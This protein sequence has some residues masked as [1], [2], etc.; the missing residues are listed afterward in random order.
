MKYLS[1]DSSGRWKLRL[2]IPEALRKSIGKREFKH[3][4]GH[5]SQSEA[6]RRAHPILNDWHRQLDAAKQATNTTSHSAAPATSASDRQRLHKDKY[7]YAADTAEQPRA[8]QVHQ[9]DLD[10]Y[11]EA[12]RV[13]L[14][15]HKGLNATLAFVDDDPKIQQ[16]ALESTLLEGELY[17]HLLIPEKH[18]EEYA[19][20]ELKD[21]QPRSRDQNISR[22]RNQFI[23]DFPI[24]SSTTFTTAAAQDWLDSYQR[25]PSPPSHDT[26]SSYRNQAKAY[27]AWLRRKGY[28]TLPNAID[29]TTLPKVG[30]KP[31][32]SRRRACTVEELSKLH[33]GMKNKKNR[34]HTLEAIFMIAIYTGCRIEEIC[35]L[36]KQDIQKHNNR[37][38]I[39]IPESKTMAGIGRQIP[40]H[41]K[42]EPVI[43]NLIESSESKYLIPSSSKMKYGERSSALSK[44]FGR[45]KTSL[46]FD[47]SVVFHSL[48]R[49]F[50]SQFESMGADER[51]IADIVGH[52]KG[53]MTY[54]VYGSGTPLDERFA[55]IDRLDYPDLN[56]I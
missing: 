51:V 33:K 30:K 38:Y 43:Q 37:S 3:S 15:R 17:G 36:R 19:Q 18:L 9:F 22:I 47:R 35:S 56:L 23:K 40:I 7:T 32:S 6:E 10:I 34:D 29:E 42:L 13:S 53:T 28:L 46:G 2:Q 55:T 11:E 8:D 20:T 49:T 50:I 21:L 41:H 14:A 39:V 31:K 1:Q 52:E 5:L 25:S 27:V 12:A 54:G 4:L 48:R 24:L 26:L 44:K 45:L 16:S